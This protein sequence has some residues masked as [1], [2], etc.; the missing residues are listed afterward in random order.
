MPCVGL[1][2]RSLASERE[3]RVHALDCSVIVTG[4]IRRSTYQLVTRYLQY[5]MQGH[6]TYSLI[7]SLF[8]I[9]NVLQNV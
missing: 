3:K 4:R 1:E 5:L 7:T 9:F 6:L 8:S 2:H